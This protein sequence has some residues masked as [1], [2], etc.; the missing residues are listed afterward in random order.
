M[1]EPRIFR[2]KYCR[3]RCTS[4]SAILTTFRCGVGGRVCWKPTSGLKAVG[5]LGNLVS[6]HQDCSLRD[7]CTEAD[8]AWR[9]VGSGRQP[10][11]SPGKS[12]TDEA[13][14]IQ[15]F[16]F[17]STRSFAHSRL[18]VWGNS[19]R[20]EPSYSPHRPRSLV[21]LDLETAVGDSSARLRRHS[22]HNRP[23]CHRS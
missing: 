1:K 16:I 20:K 22:H 13:L 15:H 17:H 21:I 23:P 3:H 19:H 4:V 6:A 8:G 12:D 2:D 9:R 14:P 7:S 11:R 18:Y 10:C 5:T